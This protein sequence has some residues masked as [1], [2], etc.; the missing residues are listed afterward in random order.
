MHAKIKKQV[1]ESA[2]P[3]DCTKISCIRKV[4]EPR[5]RKLSA[6]EIFWI[7]VYTV[8]SSMRAYVVGKVSKVKRLDLLKV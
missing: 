7:Y 2:A 3:S 6:N 4:G 5:I 8:L 1:R